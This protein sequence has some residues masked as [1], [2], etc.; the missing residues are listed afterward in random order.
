M[1]F[2]PKSTLA[3]A[4][5]TALLASQLANA[6]IVIEEGTV[7]ENPIAL[8]GNG[9][10]TVKGSVSSH[11]FPR[12]YPYPWASAVSVSGQ[13]INTN[14]TIEETGSVFGGYHEPQD[15]NY[16][17]AAIFV[18]SAQGNLNITNSGTINLQDGFPYALSGIE[19]YSHSGDV[20]LTGQIHNTS[21]GSIY[22]DSRGLTL[23]SS[24]SNGYLT[25]FTGNIINDGTIHADYGAINL[26]GRYET[27][28]HPENRLKFSGNITNHGTLS[29]GTGIHVSSADINGEIYTDGIINSENYN[30]V[31]LYGTQLSGSITNNGSIGS[32]HNKCG[33]SQWDAS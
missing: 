4:I 8:D 23:K 31:N 13:E 5:S 15:R 2:F 22:G 17:S 30:G 28:E 1:P 20:N 19:I 7:S 18:D 3:V 10:L 14:I 29:G 21:S 26:S 32:V 27:E 16:V 24:Y 6:N 25:S 11:R 33:L 9:N 12:M